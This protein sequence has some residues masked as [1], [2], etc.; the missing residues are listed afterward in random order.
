MDFC[1]STTL[2]N[3]QITIENHL[4]SI[5]KQAVI[6]T[7]LEGI[8]AAP[9]RISSMFFYDGEGS[10]LFE[11]ITRLPEYYPT[12]TEKNLLRQL[13]RTYQSN[14]YSSDI[15]EL[16]SGDC[17][18][19][20]ILFDALDQISLE[21]IRYVPVDVSCEAIEKS[22]HALIERFPGLT[23]HGIVAD[24]LSQL[25]ELPSAEKR[26]FFFLGG[27]IGNMTQT[28]RRLFFHEL[29]TIMQPQDILVLGIDM[30]KEKAIIE[31]AYNDESGTTAA[32]NR[33]IL[34]VVNSIVNTD[35]DPMR[36]DHVAFYNDV[37]SR[38]EMHLK[39]TADMEVK[40]PYLP[41]ALIIKKGEL[42]HTEYSHKF[43]REE[44]SR[45][46]KNCGLHIT[47]TVCDQSK[48]FSL[49]QIAKICADS[50]C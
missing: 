4:P 11:E 18:K 16:G 50:A 40:C 29:S 19:I 45:Q 49:V 25:S 15:V 30:V 23:I 46:L 10:R 33:N 6:K 41:N 3:K 13:A 37:N 9:R 21:T 14:I 36:F 5:G 43:T 31:K 32:F 12:R 2:Q 17:T 7:I 8:T 22:A 34:N 47:S 42:I 27:T 24:F 38:I 35:F 39:A 28:Q 26:I 20:S 44:I 1:D 48:W